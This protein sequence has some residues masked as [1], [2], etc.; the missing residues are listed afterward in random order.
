MK[1]WLRNLLDALLLRGKTLEGISDR[2]DAFLHGLAVILLISLLAGLPA[3]AVDL[4][5]GFQPP[6]AV[7]P[8]EVRVQLEGPLNAARPW[9]RRAGVPDAVAD[10]VLQ[11]T[12][13]NALLGA[14][15]ANRVEQLPTALP[16]PLAQGFA[17]VGEWLSRP[18]TNSPFPLAAAALSTWL[19]Y[20]L[21][22]MLAAKLLGGRATLHGFFGATAFFAVPHL[23][24]LF[25]PVPVLG[26]AFGVIAFLW[27]LVIYVIATAMSHRLS[28]GRAV[29]AVFAPAVL[30]AAVLLLLGLAF[31]AILAAVA[32]RPG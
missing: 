6:V 10:Q 29:V 3:L 2:P 4:V 20:G 22:V 5:R 16:R 24:D 13:G 25:E 18:F 26:P 14:T 11:T 21:W 32:T 27:G 8:G 7:E 19:G 28:A 9:L 23:L 31:A 17:S 15:I 12:A 1:A 30:F